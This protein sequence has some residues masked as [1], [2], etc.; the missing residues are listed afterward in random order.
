MDCLLVDEQSSMPEMGNVTIGTLRKPPINVASSMIASSR[1]LA[2]RRPRVSCI[3]LQRRMTDDTAPHAPRF[4][5]C[6]HRQSHCRLAS[7][8][9]DDDER[10]LRSVEQLLPPDRKVGR[11]LSRA[12]VVSGLRARLT[13][14]PAILRS[15]D[16]APKLLQLMK[17]WRFRDSTATRLGE[18][19]T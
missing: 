13:G 5:R 19:R 17:G 18:T 1:G 7:S 6:R 14:R 9:R 8:R 2:W 15:W 10:R 3:S 12:P 4:V 16:P 11:P